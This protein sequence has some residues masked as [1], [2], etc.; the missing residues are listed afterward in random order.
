MCP[1]HSTRCR[2]GSVKAVGWKRIAVACAIAAPLGIAAL[3]QL[4]PKQPPYR[5]RYEWRMDVGRGKPVG[6]EPL[7]ACSVGGPT[8]LKTPRRLV[9]VSAEGV[10]AVCRYVMHHPEWPEGEDEW[11]LE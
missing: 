7:E 10:D 1:A 4:R 6:R 11:L 3:W 2:C 9:A 5:E 8:V